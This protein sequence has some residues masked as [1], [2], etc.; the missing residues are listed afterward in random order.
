MIN[1]KILSE[2][3]SV[4]H[5]GFQDLAISGILF[6]SIWPS[7]ITFLVLILLSALS[8]RVENTQNKK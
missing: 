7:L 3:A 5:F 6:I 2:S 4:W 1:I 8:L